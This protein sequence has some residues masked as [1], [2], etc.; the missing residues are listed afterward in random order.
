MYKEMDFIVVADLFFQSDVCVYLGKRFISETN[1]V[2]SI[3]GS[4]RKTVVNL[5]YPWKNITF[6]TG[7]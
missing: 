6:T 5:S 7:F 3:S 4:V 2:I 1:V